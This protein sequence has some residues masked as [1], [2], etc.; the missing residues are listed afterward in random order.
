MKNVVLNC[1]NNR[2][3]DESWYIYELAPTVSS[4]SSHASTPIGER[5]HVGVLVGH[6]IPDAT[7][8]NT[9]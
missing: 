4:L 5:M 2:I 6:F 8:T 3:D 7:V 1:V 9:D